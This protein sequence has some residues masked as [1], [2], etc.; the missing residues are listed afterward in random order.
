MHSK[1]QVKSVETVVFKRLR[2]FLKTKKITD[3]AKN[4]AGICTVFE[5]LLHIKSNRTGVRWTLK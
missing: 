4:I 1:V 3:D 5:K 2:S